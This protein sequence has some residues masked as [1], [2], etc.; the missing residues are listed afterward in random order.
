M[1]LVLLVAFLVFG[2]I[3]GFRIAGPVGALLSAILVL[4]LDPGVKRKIDRN[5]T[6]NLIRKSNLSAPDRLFFETSFSMFAKLAKVDGRVNPQEIE[7]LEQI[8]SK[9]FSLGKV[10]RGIAITVFNKAKEDSS[11]FRT[12]AEKFSNLYQSR[13]VVL[14]TM[15]ESLFVVAIA[16]GKLS[17]S[18]EVLLKNAADAFGVEERRYSY[19]YRKY[20]G[21]DSND[22]SEP[23][24]RGG[25]ELETAYQ[26][27]GSAPQ[28]SDEQIK[29]RY[30]KL[31]SEYHPDKLA[32]KGL[33]A[34]FEQFAGDKF[35]EIQQA[36][37]IVKKS[38][39]IS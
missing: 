14:R 11:N 39:K 23:E 28:D 7:A 33:P 37:E 19:I 26:N 10:G 18:E 12:H 36:Y 13:P 32:G 8:M 29:S 3:V 34:G 15:L 9:V 24:N 35:N 1:R 17:K 30:R 31:V 2:V 6:I 5:P 22:H 21:I 38:R 20:C 4:A 27:L 25:P 16:D